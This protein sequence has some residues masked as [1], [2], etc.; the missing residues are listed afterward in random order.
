MLK[1][2]KYLHLKE[3]ILMIAL[4]AF[5]VLQLYCDVTLP[6]YTSEIVAKMQA[7]AEAKSILSTGYIMLAYAAVSVVSTLI[8]SA[9][10]AFVSTSLGRR[11]RGEVFSHAV[12]LSE[13]E[14]KNFTP[15]SLLTRTSNDVQQVVS[16][17]VLGLRLGIGA[18]LMAIMAII[19]ISQSGFEFTVLTAVGVFILLAGIL[20]ILVFVSP[21]FK[22]IQRL[23]DKLNGT[24]RE[25]LSGV[26]VI[27]A[28]NAEQFQGKKFEKVNEDFRKNNV[29]TGRMMAALNP[30][31]MI[32]NYGL[33]L[34]IYWLGCFL[35][36][37]DNNPALFPEMF[38]FTQLAGQ[39]VL[40]FM[41]LLML[42]M[43]I[44]RAQ[45][46]AK[47]I[48]EV[49]NTKP[50][51]VDG[52]SEN[53]FTEEGTVTFENVSFG[54]ENAE[55]RVLENLNFKIEKGQTFAVIGATGSGKSTL[56][57]LVL[58]FFDAADGRVL[59]DGVDVKDIPQE[60]LRSVIGYV[61][62]KSLLFSGTVEENIRFG[63]PDLS[64]EDMKRAAE[65]ACADGFISE[66]DNGYNA[67]V[68]QG[69]KNFSGGQRQRLCIARAVAVKPQ[70]YL[71]DDCF[72]ALDFAT[73][74][75]VRTNIKEYA[76][77]A[78]K[79]IVAQRIG[80]IRDADCILVLD[81]GRPVGLGT[82]KQLMENCETYRQI[83]LTQLSE[84]ELAV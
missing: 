22:I 51:V 68:A 5:L 62:Q 69:G 7:G 84:E 72:S 27:R 82:H 44:P 17:L 26:R 19:K 65:I 66:K 61:P 16:A 11:I 49:L 80:T 20:G 33:M 31:I 4:L 39:V 24:M 41:V 18:P 1:L 60:K 55:E 70:I 12:N 10:S 46:S 54:Y 21:K 48:N 50:S 83:A 38:A 13:K 30:L 53:G 77:D 74:A 35:I 52:N 56:L 8:C 43:M 25:N 28:Y 14:Y 29:F 63:N 40:A 3:W 32:V 9:L 71:F 79:L 59:V 57:K 58:R 75:R 34:G 76:P 47:R 15:S 64:D 37:R 36:V 23:T 67:E 73:D 2:L 42:F 81:K 45:V 78:T 6:A